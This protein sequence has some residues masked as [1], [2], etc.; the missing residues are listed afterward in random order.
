MS[1][2]VRSTTGITITATSSASN[3]DLIGYIYKTGVQDAK[4][5]QQRRIGTGSDKGN[6]TVKGVLTLATN[7][8]VEIFVD[9]GSGTGTVTPDNCHISIKEL[10]VN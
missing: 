9:L 7:D 1:S 10:N 3:V 4:T 2:V 8:Y 6:W 5:Q